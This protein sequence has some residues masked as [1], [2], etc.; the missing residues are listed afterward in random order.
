MESV[1]STLDKDPQDLT[2]RCWI[3]FEMNLSGVDTFL[4]IPI[5]TNGA[6]RD[7]RF[8]YYIL[9]LDS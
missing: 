4:P 8:I 1:H 7:R 5:P 2:E 3:L 9:F 6:S